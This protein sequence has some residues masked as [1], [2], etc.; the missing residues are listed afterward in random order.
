M[1]SRVKTVGQSGLRYLGAGLLVLATCLLVAMLLPGGDAALAQGSGYALSWH[2][3]DGGG[4]TFSTGGGYSLGGTLGQPDA[5][6]L[7]GAGYTLAGGFWQA[8]AGEVWHTLY[9]PLVLRSFP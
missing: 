3:I 1:R 5:G 8:G 7:A 2:T 4:G 9:L 6:H